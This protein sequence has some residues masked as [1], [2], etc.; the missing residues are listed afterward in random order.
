MKH[1]VR[2]A[3]RRAAVLALSCLLALA[4][5]PAGAAAPLRA[6]GPA[7]QA[8]NGAEDG[9]T[10]D[11]TEL[12]LTITDGDAFPKAYLYLENKPADSYFVLW[13]SS[14]PL[15]AVVDSDGKVTARSEG[16]A[17]ITASTDRGDT[18]RCTVTVCREADAGSPAQPVLNQSSMELVIRHDDRNP[19]QQLTLL[20]AGGAA[21][22]VSQWI[23]SDPE[24]VTA[25]GGLVQALQP[26][27]ATVTALTPAG[28]ALRCAVTVTSE[29]GKVILSREILLMDEP[30]SEVRLSA[31]V[32]VQDGDLVPIT[33]VSKNPGVAKVNA[34]GK[35]T[36]VA[37]GETVI[38]AFT[39]EGQSAECRVYVGTAAQ[40]FRTAEFLAGAWKG[41]GLPV[42]VVLP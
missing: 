31:V 28:T 27:T 4:A 7:L 3:V 9:M 19:S 26:G 1:P 5:L 17:V 42:P 33:W 21:D 13:S 25:E 18:A 29:I 36:A 10:L 38:T 24:V 30:G 22:T 20:D 6:A 32:A 16:T 23:S 35:V 14:N 15:V 11:P 34:E 2:T 41:Y 40:Q 12:T 8:E 39:P 37:D